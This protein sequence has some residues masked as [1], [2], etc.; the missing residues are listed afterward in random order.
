MNND[1]AKKQA[2]KQIHTQINK[3]TKKEL[4]S[5]IIFS[6]NSLALEDSFYVTPYWSFHLCIPTIYN[7]NTKQKTH[8]S[9]KLNT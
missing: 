6:E 5:M 3:Q 4:A 8:A 7:P 9:M 1:T 2:K